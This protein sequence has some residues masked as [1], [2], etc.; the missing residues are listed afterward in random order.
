MSDPVTQLRSE[1]AAAQHAIAELSELIASRSDGLH[2]GEPGPDDLESMRKQIAQA[3]H[4]WIAALDAVDDPIFLHDREF[5]ILRANRAYQRHAGLPFGEFI[6]RPYY[7]IFPRMDGPLPGCQHVLEEKI[8]K[9][10]EKK[11]KIM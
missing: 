8:D 7:E 11:K 5:R 4:E 1:L 2:I 10:N 3:H 9:D 6:G